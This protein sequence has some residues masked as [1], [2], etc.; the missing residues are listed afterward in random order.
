MA[1]CDFFLHIQQ[2]DLVSLETEFVPNAQ[3]E[4]QA[5]SLQKVI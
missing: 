4:L 5:G 1:F 2:A 3:N